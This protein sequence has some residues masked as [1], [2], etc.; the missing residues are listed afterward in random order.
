MTS[1]VTIND[2][3]QHIVF[4]PFD[5]LSKNKFR[6]ILKIVKKDKND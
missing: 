3:K 6:K 2:K 4:K 5:K 1:T